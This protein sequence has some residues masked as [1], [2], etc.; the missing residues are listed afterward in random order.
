MHTKADISHIQATREAWHRHLET[1]RQCYFVEL[2]APEHFCS[3]GMVAYGEYAAAIT[4]NPSC[5]HVTAT[6]TKEA[7]DET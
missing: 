3:A 2:Y 1:C 7:T 5:E 4:A 6:D